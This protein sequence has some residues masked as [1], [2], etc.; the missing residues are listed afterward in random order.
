MQLRNV[1]PHA[2]PIENADML[3][4][5]RQGLQKAL[6]VFMLLIGTLA[7]VPFD[8]VKRVRI[9]QILREGVEPATL[10]VCSCRNV[11]NDGVDKCLTV[12]GMDA[13]IGANDDAGRQCFVMVCRR[14]ILSWSGMVIVA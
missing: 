4:D 1:V 8:Q 5:M 12:I 11:G 9:D 7:I 3:Y 14:K 6:G 2:L 13:V 10:D